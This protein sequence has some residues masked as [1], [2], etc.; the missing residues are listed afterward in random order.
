MDPY[1]NNSDQIHKTIL[2]TI[3]EI[4]TLG[5]QAKKNVSFANDTGGVQ[6]GG[7]PAA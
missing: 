1:V 6:T 2:G 4:Y 7:W 3:T 5:A